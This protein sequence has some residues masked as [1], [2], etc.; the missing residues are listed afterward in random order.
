MSLLFR[1]WLPEQDERGRRRKRRCPWILIEATD[2]AQ[3]LAA[4]P[5]ARRI[6]RAVDRA[7]PLEER[8]AA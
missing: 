1:V 5:R 8:R 2:E 6:D 7:H 4:F 3:V